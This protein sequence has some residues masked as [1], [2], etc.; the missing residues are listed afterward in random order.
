MWEGLGLDLVSDWKSNVSVS[1][2]SRIIGSRLQANM[3]SFLLHCK[4]A[5][6]SFWMQ[7]VKIVYWFTSQ[8]D[9]VH[10]TERRK[11]AEH[12]ATCHPHALHLPSVSQYRSLCQNGSCFH[13]VWSESQWTV[14]LRYLIN[15]SL[16]RQ[17][18]DAIKH[19]V[20]NSIVFQ[21][22]TAPVCNQQGL[23]HL[24]V[25]CIAHRMIICDAAVATWQLFRTS[26]LGRWLS[27]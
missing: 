12:L 27:W 1:S 17:M 20:D 9:C 8:N 16:S 23:Y 3:H 7:G 10:H 15:T 4:I 26:G 11:A 19:I 2:R 22:D 5:R 24:G 6:T 14:L 25:R 18:L 21:Q 13:Q